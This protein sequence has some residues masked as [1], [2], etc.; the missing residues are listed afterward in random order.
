VEDQVTAEPRA[1]TSFEELLAPLLRADFFLTDGRGLVTRWGPR[2]AR[3]F[4]REAEDV[5][6]RPA[7]D[8]VVGGVP[9]WKQHLA[10]EG[11]RP[12]SRLSGT[13]IGEGF[14]VELLVFPVLLSES[15]EMS[16]LLEALA[17]GLT[18]QERLERIERDHPKALGSLVHPPSDGRLA[19]LV[20]AYTAPE[21]DEPAAPPTPAVGQAEE[22]LSRIGELEREVAQLRDQAHAAMALAEHALALA[23][24]RPAPAPAERSELDD[25]AQPLAAIALDGRFESINPAFESLVGY[26]EAD[27]RHARW[28][29]LADRDKLAEHRA[30]LA[31]LATGEIETARVETVYMHGQGLTVPV[32]GMLELVRAEDGSPR[33]LRLSVD[34]QVSNGAVAEPLA[35]AA[36]DPVLEPVAP[37][38]GVGDQHDL[39][40]GEGGERVLDSEERV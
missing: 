23:E 39:V 7:F 14:D 5:I 1:G 32:K 26:T 37:G 20:V 13:A 35:S 24:H 22:D 8:A 29:S 18:S 28:P 3:A 38:L 19:G 10:G 2:P 31:R 36:H 15:L 6:G 25:S 16:R 21:R 30:L 33:N 12:E 17:V 9:Q 27:F 4:A 34:H 40:G 11:P